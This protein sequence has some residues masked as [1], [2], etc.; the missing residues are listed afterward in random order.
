MQ[1]H[2]LR[3]EILIII[4]VL[5]VFVFVV[6]GALSGGEG[7]RYRA[8]VTSQ[9]SAT[10]GLFIVGTEWMQLSRENVFYRFTESEEGGYSEDV[11][12]DVELHLG[13][14]Y[15]V[16]ISKIINRGLPP[17]KFELSE[18]LALFEGERVMVLRYEIAPGV[19]CLVHRNSELMRC[20][21]QP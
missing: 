2:R 7:G 14:F 18:R 16:Q 13:K 4:T 10:G 8:D 5:L 21:A 11:V 3:I 9:E 15:G 17:T 12:A 1:G 20:M 19:I 6:F